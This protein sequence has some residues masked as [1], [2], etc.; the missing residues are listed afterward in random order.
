MFI[1]IL[2]SGVLKNNAK[3]IPD[4]EVPWVKALLTAMS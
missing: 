1:L 4:F 2:Y 3:Y